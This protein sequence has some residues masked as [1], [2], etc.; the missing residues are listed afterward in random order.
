MTN[1]MDLDLA[2]PEVIKQS[3]VLYEG[4]RSIFDGPMDFGKT[5]FRSSTSFK[6]CCSS[7]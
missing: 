5:K 6:L 2:N 4:N 3:S 1:R 7:N